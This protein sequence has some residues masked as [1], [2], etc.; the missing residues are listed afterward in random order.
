[1]AGAGWLLLDPGGRLVLGLT[2]A[3]F[4][5]CSLYVPAYLRQRAD[6]PNRVFCTCLL[7]FDAMLV[8]IA[9]AHHLGLM[10][11]AIEAAT[12]S[13]APMLYFSRN[14]RSLEAVWKYLVLSSVG[15]AF[16]LLAVFMLATAQ[17]AG[18]GDQPLVLGDLVTGA[19]A[20]NKGWLRAAFVFALAGFGT[21]MGLAPL[22]T[23]KPDAYGEAPSLVGGLMA[24][25]LTSCAFLGVARF[26]DKA[27]RNGHHACFAADPFSVGHM[28]ARHARHRCRSAGAGDPAGGRRDDR[29]AAGLRGLHQAHRVLDAP[30]PVRSV[31]CGHPHEQW[32]IGGPHAAHGFHDFQAQAHPALQV[33]AVA[34]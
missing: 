32:T 8:L 1:M 2:T 12:L 14:Q 10:W 25:C 29:D 18:V 6:R 20:L 27:N 17:P 15:I 16:A 30:R 4:L 26:R 22:H 19:G 33:A 23:W 11:V 3:L 5:L 21:K 7:L 31:H 13:T 9:E 28:V 34:I 24:G